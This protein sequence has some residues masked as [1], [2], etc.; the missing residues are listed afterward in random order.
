MR[1][2]GS[3]NSSASPPPLPQVVPSLWTPDSL[4]GLISWDSDGIMGDIDSDVEPPWSPSSSPPRRG[5]GSSGRSKRPS[6]YTCQMCVPQDPAQ[7]LWMQVKTLLRRQVKESGDLHLVM[8]IWKLVLGQ[9]QNVWDH[10]VLGCQDCVCHPV[11]MKWSYCSSSCYHPNH[12]NH[13]CLSE[14][15]CG[16]ANWRD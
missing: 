10:D 12:P 14:E 9:E 16:H 2:S 7:Q 3:R 4:P 1:G 6:P 8:V 11:T 5:T 13:L 15:C